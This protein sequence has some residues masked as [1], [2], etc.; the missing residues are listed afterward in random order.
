[1]KRSIF[2]TIILFLALAFTTR[3]QE[4]SEPVTVFAGG[5]NYDP[6]FAIDSNGALHVV[7]THMI[8]DDYRKVY[9]AKSTDQG[10]TWSEP[11]DLA[12][13]SDSRL[14]RPQVAVGLGDVIYVSY[15]YKIAAEQNTNVYLQ[16]YDGEVWSQPMVVSEGTA[17][18]SSKLAVDN[19][20]ILYIKWFYNPTGKFRIRTYF[21]GDFSQITEPISGNSNLYG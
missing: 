4:W 5:A 19:S 9:Y 13:N 20:G 1:M 12:Q 17:S 18:W 2:V 7:W 8:S 15:D 10:E 3:A 6:D 16:E 11:Y 21:N 14:T